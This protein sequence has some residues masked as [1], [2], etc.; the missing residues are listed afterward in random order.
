MMT[1]VLDVLII[2]LTVGMLK[3]VTRTTEK[4]VLTPTQ[5]NEAEDAI[6]RGEM[7]RNPVRFQ[8]VAVISFCINVGCC[9]CQIVSSFK[10]TTSRAVCQLVREYVGHRDGIW[11]L[12]VTRTQPVVLGTAS[13]GISLIFFPIH[14]PQ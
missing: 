4:S 11:D 13:A 10:A 1:I 5:Q 3:H 12:S 6:L 2:I 8:D 9:R 7:C 14:I